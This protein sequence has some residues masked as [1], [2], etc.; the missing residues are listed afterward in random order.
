[1]GITEIKA[2]A[3]GEQH[4]LF[5]RRLLTDLRALEKMLE[6]GLVQTGVR[7]IGAEQEMFLVDKAGRPAGLALDMLKALD[8]PHYTTE[9]GI[10]NLELNIDPTVFGDGCLRR[11]EQQLD[12]YVGK[13][14][15][16]A[17][18]LGADIVLTGILPTIRKSDL[19]LENMTPLPRYAVLN[20]AMTDLRGGPYEFRIKGVDDLIVK[21]DNVMLEACNTSF[22]VHFQVGPDEFA[23]LYNIAQAACAPVMAA[24]TNSPMLFGNRLWR[25]TRIALFEQSVDTRSPGDHLREKPSRV[26]FGRGWVKKSVTELYQED[27]ARFRALIGLEADEDPFEILARGE[28]PELRALRLHNGTIYRWNRA[29]YGI[30]DGKAHLRIE[31]RILP[32]GPTPVDEVANAAFWFGLMSGFAEEHPDVARE[33]SFEDALGNFFAAARHGLTAQ[34]HWFG[35]KTIPAD[36]LIMKQLVPLAREGLRHGKIDSS[37][38]DRYLGIIEERVQSG[39]TGSAWLLQSYAAMKDHGVEGERLGALT[40][41]TIARQAEGKPVHTWDLAR[42]EESGGWKQ[43]YVKVEQLM[44]TDLFTVQEDEPIDLVANLMDWGRIRHVPVE[45]YEHRLLGLVSYRSVLRAFARGM[46]DGRSAPLPVSAIMTRDLITVTPETESL[47]AIELMRKHKIACLPVV[48]GDRLV[49][50]VTE[51]EFMDI[52]G[53]LLSQKLKA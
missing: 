41:A 39:K 38:I 27:I 50:V 21:H 37:D 33:M 22:Q 26:S 42:I 40:R 18:K 28:A 3:G 32:A 14:R 44:L 12:D 34:F 7:R 11:M 17:R 31:N 10:F 8:D 16:A 1:M 4:R 52:A 36:E 43:H 13:A 47:T 20:K 2:Q 51:D 53:E 35:G 9:L 29:C 30:T 15:A 49:G 48:K 45:D 6:D 24:A 46:H 19:G 23:R 25:E 5:M